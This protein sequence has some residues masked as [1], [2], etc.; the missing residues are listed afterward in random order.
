MLKNENQNFQKNYKNCEI[1]NKKLKDYEI[2]FYK[3]D[4]ENHSFKQEIKN[5]QNKLCTITGES[6]DNQIP[7]KK[8][9]VNNELN[10]IENNT[11]YFETNNN[12][13]MSNNTFKSYD[14]NSTIPISYE[15]SNNFNFNNKN[16][17]NL[18]NNNIIKEIENTEK[19]IID[20]SNLIKEKNNQNEINYLINEIENQKI[21]LNNLKNKLI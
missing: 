8:I 17:Y 16:N 18:I 2:L 11:S 21:K 20:L 4:L 6:V 7:I 10:T 5:Y 15:N 1:L 14:K 13:L 9:D 3:L 19:T 12:N